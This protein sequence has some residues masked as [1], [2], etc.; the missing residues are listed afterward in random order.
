LNNAVEM[1]QYAMRIG[2]LS[3]E[4]PAVESQD[5]GKAHFRSRDFP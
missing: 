1:A 2:L 4:F 5:P 3:A